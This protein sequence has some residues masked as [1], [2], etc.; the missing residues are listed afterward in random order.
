MTKPIHLPALLVGLSLGA[1]L[2]AQVAAKPVARADFLKNI[3]NGF[4]GIDTN[5]DG[6]LSK[7]ELTVQQQ[8]ELQRAKTLM[9]QQVQARF[10]QLDTNKNGS[11]SP[12]EFAAM[13]GPIRTAETPEQLLKALDS[14]GDGKISGEEYRAPRIAQFNKVDAN[15][16]GVATPEEMRKAAGK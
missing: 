9:T 16:D 13:V 15:R 2:L 14:N 7:A 3:D 11:L 10:K 12:Q 1:P 5:R 6:Q 4:A 8:K